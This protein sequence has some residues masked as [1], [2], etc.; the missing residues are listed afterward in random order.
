MKALLILFLAVPT[1]GFAQA[2]FTTFDTLCF[3][4]KYNDSMFVQEVPDVS[5]EFVW[6]NVCM[7]MDVYSDTD[8]TTTPM[9]SL[10]VDFEAQWRITIDGDY[11]VFDNE[12]K[13]G[14]MYRIWYNRRTA[15]ISQ[16]VSV[17]SITDRAMMIR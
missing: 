4:Y 8:S 3:M 16:V 9:V 17:N 1:M 13:E 12:P 6:T 5:V 14:L 2:M 15:T 11:F 7:R 10:G